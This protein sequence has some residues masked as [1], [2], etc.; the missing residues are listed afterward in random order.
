[1]TIG[2]GGY[3]P[4]QAVYGPPTETAIERNIATPPMSRDTSWHPIGSTFAAPW[5]PTEAI[6]DDNIHHSFHS[7]TTLADGRLS[8]IVDP[9]A[10]TNLIGGDLSRSICLAARKNGHKPTES[11]MTAP[12][13]VAG[14]GQGLESATWQVTLP[15]A[16]PTEIG[17]GSTIHTFQSPV[18]DSPNGRKLPGLLGLRSMRRKRAILEMAPG[19]EA[20]TFPGPGDYQIQWPPG[21]I[22]IPLT[23]APSRHL[24]IVC[25]AYQ[26]I[27]HSS[28]S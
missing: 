17:T 22:R 21:T 25:D 3:T 8:I 11:R 9:G 1:M 6:N 12:F 23:R 13:H 7:Q 10:W 26:S 15:I 18:I 19:H 28:S 5:W 20:L 14:V 4:H 16:V 2:V 24:V 27:A